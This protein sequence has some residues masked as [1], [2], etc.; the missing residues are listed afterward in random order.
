M[1]PKDV[2]LKTDTPNLFHIANAHADLV[3]VEVELSE[4]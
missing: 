2:I 4:T 1:H 3:G